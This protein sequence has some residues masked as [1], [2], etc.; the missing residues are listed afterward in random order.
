MSRFKIHER[1]FTLVEVLAALLIFSLS[2]I[3]L[4]H[5]GTQS[6]RAVSVISEKSLA[7]IVAD[8]ALIKSRMK[9]L[10]LSS[11]QGV[12]TQMG[13]E[14]LYTVTTS[15]TPVNNFYSVTVTVRRNGFEQTLISRQAYRSG[16]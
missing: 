11:E 12:E 1:G 16:S 4:T 8:N 2:I 7:S 13:R 5:A 9:P 3:G 15:K 10:K 14:F 6:A